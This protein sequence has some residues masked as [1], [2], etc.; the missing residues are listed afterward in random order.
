[1][2]K[3]QQNNRMLKLRV[4]SIA[5]WKRLALLMEQPVDRIVTGLLDLHLE[6]SQARRTWLSAQEL[7]KRIGPGASAYM[8]S[9][10]LSEN[11][12]GQVVVLDV[13]RTVTESLMRR[14]VGLK[15]LPAVRARD[16]A[17]RLRTIYENSRGG[18][19]EPREDDQRVLELLRARASDRVITDYWKRAVLS[20]AFP[21]VRSFADLNRTWSTWAAP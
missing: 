19:L 3:W 6:M 17:G 13:E 15:Q 10:G 12:N 1:M 11:R 16:L 4:S 20:N 7:A 5:K 18:S 9:L 8:G 2:R 21:P 14:A